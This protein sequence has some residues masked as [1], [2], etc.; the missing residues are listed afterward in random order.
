MMYVNRLGA[1]AVAGLVVL[2]VVACGN[3]DAYEVP[4][5][6]PPIHCSIEH[7]S[8]SMTEDQH[9]C[10]LAQERRQNR[11]FAHRVDQTEGTKHTGREVCEKFG[12]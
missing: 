1:W 12:C 10:L 5:V 7:M 4:P 3:Q 6:G 8:S 11:I 2:G 9:Q